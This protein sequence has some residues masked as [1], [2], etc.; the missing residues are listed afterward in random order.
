[1]HEPVRAVASDAPRVSGAVPSAAPASTPSVEEAD[2]T[3]SAKDP[4]PTWLGWTAT[5]VSVAGLVLA[6]FFTVRQDSSFAS[7]GFVPG[8]L[9][10]WADAHGQFR[11]FPAYVLLTTAMLL[12]WWI[13]RTRSRP[14]ETRRRRRA[15]RAWLVAG[16]TVVSGVLEFVQLGISSRWFEWADIWWSWAGIAVAWLGWEAWRTLAT[17]AEGKPSR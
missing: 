17:R 3:A 11:N 2:G 16:L 8:W 9:A 12:A 13:L 14:A 1:M 7:A 5:A 10:R 15:E 4:R 6:I